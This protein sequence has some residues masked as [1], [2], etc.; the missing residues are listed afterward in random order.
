MVAMSRLF[1][2]VFCLFF[3]TLVLEA[4]STA[5]V[6]SGGP[7]IGSQRWDNYFEREPL[8]RYHGALAVESINNENDRSSLFAQIGYHVKGSATRF[9]FYTQGGGLSRL[10]ES[11]EFHNASLIVGA[12]QKA[13]LGSSGMKYFYF[14]GLRGDYTIS[15]NLDELAESTVGNPWLRVVYPFEGFVRKWIFGLS[16]GGGLE[17]PFGDLVGA[18]LQLSLHPDFTLQYNQPP[19]PNVIDPYNPGQS[20]TIQERQIRNTAIE[21]SLGLRLLRKVVYDE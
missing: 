16:V 19:I 20:F 4:Q 11:F 13:P 3:S 6:I 1:S 12:K 5:F 8:L 7:T 17:F 14:G 9:Q 21:L 18:Q 15:T 2:C 10:T